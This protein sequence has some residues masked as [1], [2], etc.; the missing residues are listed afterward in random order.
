MRVS[1]T[2]AVLGALLGVLPVL[3]APAVAREAPPV[4][5]KLV[6]EDF[7]RGPLLAEGEFVNTRDGTRRGVKV[8]MAGR[9]DGRVLTLREDF[10]YSDGEKDVKTWRFTKVG[11]GRYVGTRE[12]VIGSAEIVQDGNDIRLSY[13][14]TVRT[15]GTSYDIRFADRLALT[16]P[17]TVLNTAKLTYFIFDVGQVALT[18]RQVGPRRPALRPGS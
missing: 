2:S 14:A 9:W 6:L 16:G 15:K 11:E 12:D 8:R 3:A 18:I 17:R 4:A 1:L 5:R 7:F 13:V 10:V